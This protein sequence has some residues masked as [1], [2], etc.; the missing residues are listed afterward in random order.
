MQN[1]SPKR[2]IENIFCRIT[3]VSHMSNVILY[4][5]DSHNNHHHH[6][7][8]RYQ[9][10]P[11]GPGSAVAVPTRYGL[12]VPGIKYRWGARFSAPFQT[13]PGAHP[14]SCTMGTGSFPGVRRPGRGVDHPPHLVSK[15]KKE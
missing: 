6:H 13:G 7:F 14:A 12:D 1:C 4:H 9:S 3:C 2:A 10:Q 5:C 11:S 15:L 8:H